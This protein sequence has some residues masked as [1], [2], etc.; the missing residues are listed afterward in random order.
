VAPHIPFDTCHAT[1]N[2][3]RV[4]CVPS[5]RTTRDLDLLSTIERRIGRAPRDLLQVAPNASIVDVCAA[6]AQLVHACEPRQFANDA[7]KLARARRAM[8]QLRIAFRAAIGRE[9]ANPAR[10]PLHTPSRAGPVT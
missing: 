8:R 2:R 9:L 1:S 5:Q 6:F 7:G 4:R 10:L 3:R